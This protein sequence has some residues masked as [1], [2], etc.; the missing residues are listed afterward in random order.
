ML[1]L[2]GS[3][4]R[5]PRLAVKAKGRAGEPMYSPDD[6][7]RIDE[8]VDSLFYSFPRLVVHID[9][10]AIEVVGR[11]F[12]DLIPPGAAVLDLM[13]SWRSHWPQGHPKGRMVGLGLNAEEMADN[14]DLEEHVVHDLNREP[15]LPFDDGAFDAV[16]LT[17]S[18]QY[19][20]RPVE[21]FKQV[22]RVMKIGG[23]FVVTFSNRMFPTKAVRIWRESTDRGR[24]ELVTSYMEEAGNFGEI[25][26]G[27]VNPDS[28]PPNDPVFAVVGRKG[29]CPLE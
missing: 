12:R 9:P 25:R 7:Q 4:A 2:A 10:Q 14:P 16:A 8:S 23:V 11:L 6:F 15:E 28:S 24:I 20:T 18:A 22:N 19:L 29:E 27:F 21:T 3:E 13:S 17:V 5:G 1:Q 26:S